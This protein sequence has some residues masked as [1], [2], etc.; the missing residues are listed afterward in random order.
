MS[1]KTMK[2]RKEGRKEALDDESKTHFLY[3]EGVHP[4]QKQKSWRVSIRVNQNLYV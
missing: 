2:G 4:G 3:M 1:K